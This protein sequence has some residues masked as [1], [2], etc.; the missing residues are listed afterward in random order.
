M[1]TYKKNGMTLVEVLIATLIFSVALGVL[2]SSLGAIIDLLDIAQDRSQATSDLKNMMEK[3]RA[4]PFDA[5]TTRF[6][7]GTTDGPVTNPYTA[8]V[9]GYNLKN[10]HMIVSYANPNTDPLEILVLANWQDKKGRAFNT[11][12]STFRTR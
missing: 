12:I 2:L 4:T 1:K 3:I 6:T 5:I 8:I 9:G 11:T 7:N 10:E